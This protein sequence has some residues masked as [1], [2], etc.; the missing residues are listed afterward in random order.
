MCIKRCRK[1]ANDTI[2]RRGN[3]FRLAFQRFAEVIT[4]GADDRSDG[5]KAR[6]DIVFKVTNLSVKRACNFKRAFTEDFVDFRRANRKR[7]CHAFGAFRH[8]P[9]EILGLGFN[10]CT[11]GG[12]ADR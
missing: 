6:D 5:F 7:L 8:D 11:N 3:G 2:E 12:I 1:L 4:L 10:G 9:T